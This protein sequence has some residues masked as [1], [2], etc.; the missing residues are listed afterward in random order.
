MT[1]QALIFE[2]NAIQSWVFGSGKLR[3][4]V[5]GSRLVSGIT[6]ELLEK[7]LEALP[8][9]A[10]K[11]IQFARRAG[12]AL[13]ACARKESSIMALERVWPLIVTRYA[14]GLSFSMG[15]GSGDSVGAAYTRARI[16]M[17]GPGSLPRPDLPLA[18]PVMERSRRTGRAAV[19]RRHKEPIDAVMLAQ[20]DAE[21]LD[22]TDGP[23]ADIA[24]RLAEELSLPSSAW[25]RDMEPDA[26]G[27]F[28]YLLDDA[29]QVRNRYVAM[30]HADGNG[31]GQMLHKLD[32]G[33][34]GQAVGR[35]RRFSDALEGATFAACLAACS[36]V[37]LPHQRDGRLPARPVLLGG[38]DLS[39]IVRADLAP[40]FTRVFLDAFERQTAERLSKID[41]P[42]LD[43][44]TACAGIAYLRSNQPFYMG[45]ELAEGLC[46]HAK[47]QVRAYT[48][49]DQAMFSALCQHRCTDSLVSDW[50]A[51]L[52]HGLTLPAREGDDK[53]FRLTMETW[54]LHPGN[55]WGFPPYDGLLDLLAFF[56]QPAIARGPARRLMGLLGLHPTL[57]R[58]KYRRWLEML[59]RIDP[60]G[61]QRA[62]FIELLQVGVDTG[63]H[64]NAPFIDW[65]E[66]WATP[67]PEV[68]ALKAM[69]VSAQAL[70]V[71]QTTREGTA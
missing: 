2:V 22:R 42:S 48:G 36:A 57:A 28:P 18:T 54:A 21:E 50:E 7:T 27:G 20:L 53:L 14:P 34:D 4:I 46:R 6:G 61:R 71:D 37:L 64:E 69:G 62:R 24:S 43:G 66:H 23:V 12:G 60:D 59:G 44:L 10:A 49:P 67:I 52:E 38:D 56:E 13:I 45:M 65:D 11:D 32:F 19:A 40:H 39:F 29:G 31:L 3:A 58:E 41:G 35:W 70:E 8:D 17:A 9:A 30:I 26:D 16:D 47:K 1:W 68:L 55:E 25:P 5:G 51:L 15:H 33:D 63:R